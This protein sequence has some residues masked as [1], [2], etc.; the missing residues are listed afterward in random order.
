LV[1]GGL[2]R[3][4]GGWKAAKSRGK[5]E[6]Q[7][8]KGDERML[9]DSDFVLQ[10]LEEADETVN[11]S[12]ETNRQGYDLKTVEDRVCSIFTRAPEDLYAKRREK[13]KA[14]ARGL[15]CYFH[16]PSPGCPVRKHGEE[17][18]QATAP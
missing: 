14:R 10:V 17:W 16:S 18:R 15:F 11:R 5:G 12:Y 4:L 6:R 7:R 2:I 8:I 9:G 1:G 3:S 13:L